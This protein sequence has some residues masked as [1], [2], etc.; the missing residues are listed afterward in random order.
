MSEFEHFNPKTEHFFCAGF[1]QLFS[2]EVIINFLFL[3]A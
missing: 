2:K 3:L 1:G